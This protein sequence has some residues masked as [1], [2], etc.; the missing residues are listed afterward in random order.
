MNSEYKII[1]AFV[2]NRAGKKEITFSEFYLTLSMELKW[3]TPEDAKTFT[4]N[5]I[6][7]SLLREE[8]E[9]ITPNFNIDEIQIPTGFYPSEKIVQQKEFKKEQKQDENILDIIVEKIVEKSNLDKK[10]ITQQ[11]KELEKEKN[12]TP[13]IAALLI[14]K[15]YTLV[16]NELLDKIEKTVFKS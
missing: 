11:I 12:I 6:K 13:E 4:K 14:G 15:E 3:F 5:A 16:F 8:D 9:Q 10:T 7:H 1:I 2:F